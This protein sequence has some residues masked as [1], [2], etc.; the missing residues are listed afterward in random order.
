VRSPAKG[1]RAQQRRAEKL[2]YAVADNQRAVPVRLQFPARGV[3]ADQHRKNGQRDAYAQNI[4]EDN[5]QDERH[6]R[7][8][9]LGGCGLT[10]DHAPKAGARISPECRGE[11]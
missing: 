11:S 9:A 2:H 3:F 4:D 5:D 10:H 8:A 7:P 1:K 6:A